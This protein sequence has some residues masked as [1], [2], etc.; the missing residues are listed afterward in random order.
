MD[1]QQVL[2]S[3]ERADAAGDTQS[4][5]ALADLARSLMGGQQPVKPPPAPA[6][7]DRTWGEAATD[8]GAGLVSGAGSLVQL[9]GQLYGL[10]TGDFSDTGMLGAGNAL[11]KQGE[12]MKSAGLKAREEARSKAI[13]EAE[14][15]GQM[16]AYGT[17]AWETLKDPAL[18]TGAIAENVPNLL[19]PGGVA[20]GA[21][22][23][24]MRGVGAGLEGAAK[25]A[26]LAAARDAAIK[27]G[28]RAAIGAGA[29][30]QGADVGAQAYTDLYDKLIAQKVPPAEAASR[31]L[32][33]ARAAG[34]S[35]AVISLLANNL[36]G[37]HTI[38]K[39][40]AGSK[41]QAGRLA[42]AVE[43]VVGEGLSESVEEGGGKFA[44]N[45]AMRQ[46]DPTQSLMQGVGATAGQAAVSGAGLG[47]VTGAISNKAPPVA[48]VPPVPET[49]AKPAGPTYEELQARL[50]VI[51]AQ[52][53]SKVRNR[54]L[55][56]IRE[57]MAAIP[58][59]GE[60]PETQV[61]Q[62]LEPEKDLR[63]KPVL[64]KAEQPTEGL[65]DVV[66][67]ELPATTEVLQDAGIAPTPQELETAG[68][69]TMDLGE[70]P[71]SKPITE[72]DLAG[73]GGATA[74]ISKANRQWLT[75][76]V[77]GKRPEEVTTFAQQYPQLVPANR[78]V[79]SV[80]KNIAAVN[81]SKEYVN[82][83]PQMPDVQPAN[84]ARGRKPSVGV[85]VQPAVAS[86]PTGAAAPTEAPAEPSGQRLV[87]PEQLTGA[88]D[89]QQGSQLSPLA[90]LPEAPA[91]PDEL[92]KPKAKAGKAPAAPAVT[93]KPKAAP[94][95][96]PPAPV[97]ARKPKPLPKPPEVTEATRA[98]A[99]A[100]V[101][102]VVETAA[103]EGETPE[104]K[105][106]RELKL[107]EDR[108]A[109][110]AA[111]KAQREAQ[112]EVSRD[113]KAKATREEADEP[114]KPEH[115]DA[116]DE[117]DAKLNLYDTSEEIVKAQR[118]A[119]YIS[120]VAESPLTPK[121]VRQYAQHIVD[122]QL[123]PVD[124]AAGRKK[125]GNKLL[126]VSERAN[127]TPL[128][129]KVL[130]E[131]KHGSLARALKELGFLSKDPLAKA[132]AQR[133]SRLLGD[134]KVTI[135][136]NLAY[137]GKAHAGLAAE[138]GSE[139][140]LDRATG[141]NQEVLLHEA[142]HAASEHVLSMHHSK[143]TPQQKTAVMELKSLWEAAKSRSSITLSPDARRSLSEFVTE[144]M[145][146]PDLQ[147]QL[148]QAKWNSKTLW[149]S[150][151][152]DILRLIGVTNPT[153]MLDYAV[154]AMDT[155]F[156]APPQVVTP[157][158]TKQFLGAVSPSVKSLVDGSG[159]LS[160]PERSMLTSFL[161]AFKV[162][163][164]LDYATKFRTQTA[165]I[166]ATIENRLRSQF[167]GK[168]RDALGNFNPM[169]LYRQAQ[170][171]SKMMLQFLQTGSIE[172]EAA[173]GLWKVVAKQGT[174]APSKVYDQ[175]A[176]WSKKNGYSFEEGKKIA[177]RILEGVR[178][179]QM[180]ASNFTGAT[181]FALHKIDKT[182]NLSVD[183]QI[184][185][186][187]AEYAVQPDLQ[188]MSK[189]MDEARVALVDHM[190]TVGR[191]TPEMGKEWKDV[192]G[193]VPFDRMEQFAEKF[194]KVKRGG[195][196]GLAQVGKLP[197]LKGSFERPVGDV[198][199][200]Y[201]NTLGWMLRQVVHTDAT[202]R[203]LG[204]LQS[205]GYAK[206]YNTN[207][208]SDHVVSAYVGGELKYWELPSKY[209]EM[210]F[211]DL[212]IPQ[213]RWIQNLGKFSNVLRATVTALP[214]FALKQVT[215]DVQRAIMTS[216]V[217]S[218]AALL[219]MALTNFPKLVVAEL[220]GIEHPLVK[221]FGA[222]GLSGEYDFQQN[223][224][225]DSL[226]KDMGY[227]KRSTFG[228]LMHKLE[229]ITRA[230]DL[231]VR[232]AIYE[233]TMK[234]SNNDVLLA[235]TRSREFIN[236]RRRGASEAIGAMVTT[237][238]FFNAYV[239]GMD[240]LYRAAS[241]KDASASNGRALARRMFWTRALT[242]TFLS[243]LYALSKSDDDEYK[244][245]DLR[246][247]DNNWVF[248]NGYKLSVP[249]EMGA[250]FKV[251]PERVVEY[252][253]RQGTVEEQSAFEVVASTLSYMYEQYLGRV[254]PIPQ[255]IKPV[256]EAWSNKSFLTGRALEGF[257]HGQMD[258]SMRRT[259][260][261]SELAVAI[262]KFASSEL[263]MEV[264][265][266][267]IDN[268]L[269]GYFG[270]TAALLTATTD[271]M[272]NPDKVDRPLHKWALFSNYMYDPIGT[273]KVTEFYEQ[274]D[275]SMRATVTLKELMRTDMTKAAA[276]AE[277]HMDALA[278]E[279]A[280]QSTLNQL[281]QTRAYR[282]FLN[283]ADGAATM[284]QDERESQLE[285]IKKMEVQLTGWV[286]EAKT[287][288]K[289]Q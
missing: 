278:L 196:R 19:L 25:E 256:L 109:R 160:T 202:V 176:A 1:L 213:A 16:S 129:P 77:V 264:S 5:Q 116:V 28:T 140:V 215:D 270:S 271:A 15:K 240:V 175:L 225:A 157:A 168:V 147:A 288:L 137:K 51:Q 141:L 30:Q 284:T 231:A 286:R 252:M 9:P 122:S 150:F 110:S 181:D 267:M 108:Q 282:K 239:Q 74:S 86:E 185:A 161:D 178:L 101:P 135:V 167:D 138:D 70:V 169:G 158:V 69:Q 67:A 246:T 90:D 162:V 23:L 272:L 96:T 216:G 6:S 173:T 228:T 208:R 85:P 260:N 33:L 163:P 190:V 88:G 279:S 36:P 269:R 156:D 245:M 170:D 275:E 50:E 57:Q 81:A 263:K 206:F 151:K 172:K 83:N 78:F 75:D 148:R 229:G 27:T 171:Y 179:D 52:P 289:T 12:S 280:V 58:A 247:R 118:A 53:N 242:V 142:V 235:Q 154:A 42:G 139:I 119:A 277:A 71:A 212:N 144:A 204:A 189:L 114:L 232:A 200:N 203:T 193:Y 217:K 63:G 95:V 132:I 262:A 121:A 192:V 258:P 89:A 66:G 38:E 10:A 180:R 165:D 100:E 41:G 48:E 143:W 195:F 201:M 60:L 112:R 199:G 187:V 149:E 188:E 46:V 97:V 47:G 182:S 136:D 126:G 2:S 55:K 104:E 259:E 22:S 207:P 220:R 102:K 266:I 72:A 237:I 184:D 224:P 244:D 79:K 91:A 35:G 211:K 197:E 31:A 117:I 3:L 130:D 257:H 127:E 107:E 59:Q 43:G 39:T 281:E 276:Y 273:R 111:Q 26:A 103:A 14:K 61:P 44:Q 62:A 93:A 183:Q 80:L 134:T 105:S 227:A 265:P 210:A 152:H 131:L 37:A 287:A 238:P 17:A 29:V 99:V 274:R 92:F 87:P 24:A 20:K 283:S 233:Q 226:L 68:Q 205:I 21:V 221:Q 120:A 230:S 65:R 34:A 40:L 153:N 94:V 64:P 234:E 56:T 214:P 4:A 191:L 124:V 222:Y 82:A 194:S 146:N 8:V 123:D 268:T 76:N 255:A 115:A 253:R 133:L 49:P 236:F 84:G 261:T 223:K 155:I 248:P 125:A 209:D 219:R 218:P 166:A 18:L 73:L 7:K 11:Q 243:S 249:G 128:P 54:Q 198:F 98:T 164:G 159:D 174:R 251:I 177:S 13:Q 254:N 145:T 285:E 45:V 106:K 32:N 113:E 186:M 250:V 241:G